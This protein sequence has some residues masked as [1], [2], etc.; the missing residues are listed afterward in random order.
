M[1][2]KK[3]KK[4]AKDLKLP[5]INNNKKNDLIK[6]SNTTTNKNKE[7]TTLSKMSRNSTQ[8]K[9]N[10]TSNTDDL[11]K[12][13]PQNKNIIKSNTLSDKGSNLLN[14]NRN[15]KD[16]SKNNKDKNRDKINDI[17]NNFNKEKNINLNQI[18]IDFNKE[19]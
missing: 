8:T 15:K 18:K 5:L 12:K 6:Q 16:K 2:E 10:K 13:L 1:S 4:D 3:L 9:S 11:K 14:H 19:N 17:I 7:N